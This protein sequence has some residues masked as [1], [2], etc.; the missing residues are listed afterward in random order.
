MADAPIAL[1]EKFPQAAARPSLDHAAYTVPIGEAEIQKVRARNG[2]TFGRFSPFV[3]AR[4]FYGVWR[5]GERRTFALL[6][7]MV[8]PEAQDKL[9]DAILAAFEQHEAEQALAV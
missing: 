5:N 4:V 8:D 7:P 6:R 2:I 3:S 9:R 1:N